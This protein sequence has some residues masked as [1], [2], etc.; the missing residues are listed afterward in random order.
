MPRHIC[1]SKIEFLCQNQKGK[2]NHSEAQLILNPFD[3][4]LWEGNPIMLGMG[5]N[6]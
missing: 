3:P 5:K 1:D 2:V 6:L 4:N